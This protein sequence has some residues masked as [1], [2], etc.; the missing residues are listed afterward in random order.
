MRSLSRLLH[1][2]LN[3]TASFDSG[4]KA[5]G[6]GRDAGKDVPG[7]NVA[8]PGCRFTVN[9]T[10]FTGTSM[11]VDIVAVIG[12]VDVVIASFTN[13]TGVSQETITVA[14]CPSE[15]K[16]VGTATAVTDFDATFTSNRLV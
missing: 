3:G 2:E 4:I 7:P 14:D 12:G 15:V 16:I 9:C 13:V 5:T 11:A 10:G 6:V 1:T 8:A